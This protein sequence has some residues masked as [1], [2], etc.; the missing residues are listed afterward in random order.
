MAYPC[1]PLD[2]GPVEGKPPAAYP[3]GRVGMVSRQRLTPALPSTAQA[4]RGASHV[5]P[6]IYQATG[7]RARR[8]AAKR[9]AKRAAENVARQAETT[10]PHTR[11]MS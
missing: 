2:P 8:I 9:T 5:L 1:P 10:K 3:P 4:H 6:L 11:H 7:R